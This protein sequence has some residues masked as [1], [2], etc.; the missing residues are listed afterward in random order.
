MT[1]LKVRKLGKIEEKRLAEGIFLLGWSLMVIHMYIAYSSLSAYSNS[2]VSAIALFFFLF[3]VV[4]TK[5][6]AREIGICSI[7]MLIGILTIRP[8]Q[9]MRVFWFA[10]VITA[11]K[12]VDIEKII[13]VTYGITIIC[14]I[15]FFISYLLNIS[16]DE[17]IYLEDGG[18]RHG[19][20]LGHPNTLQ[21]YVLYFVTM[22][23]YVNYVKL[24]RWILV[25][26]FFLSIFVY[27][28]TNSRTGIVITIVVLVMAWL[29]RFSSFRS[30]TR[31]GV[32]TISSIYIIGFSLL[33]IIYYRY[34]NPVF[35][36]LN[37]LLTK[38]ITQAAYFYS[39]YGTKLFGFRPIELTYVKRYIYLDMG[40]ATM[41][42][43]H[44]LI[45]FTIIVGS[46]LLLLH[47]YTKEKDDKRMLILFSF[48]L[49]L[50]PENM[51]TYIFLN[52]SML[53]ISE[54]I[55][56]SKTHEDEKKN[57]YMREY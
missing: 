9:D 28:F 46:I 50:G 17:T 10:L 47:R 44:G 38:R 39:A 7:L 27:Y 6:T 13:K 30:L 19:F 31:N 1:K 24:K 40:Y 20:G 54:L 18:L 33:P 12:N 36:F 22:T 11:I 16:I 23:I 51:A 21:A 4:Y 56:V 8:S 48:V 57:I 41:Y 35:S 53:F 55:F 14:C 32:R 2:I 43:C 25:T 29:I 45:F 37:I 49:F 52:V 15:L 26:L 5:Y 42:I 34:I 3:K